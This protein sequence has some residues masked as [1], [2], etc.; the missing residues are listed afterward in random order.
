MQTLED[1]SAELKE[2]VRIDDLNLRDKQMMLPASKHKWIARTMDF[3]RQ[4]NMLIRKKKETKEHVLRALETNG[5][6]NGIPKA[7][8]NQKI[9]SSDKIQKINESIEDVELL[10]EYLEKVEQ[11][12]KSMSFDFSNLVK[13]NLSETT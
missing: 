10:I 4:R 2:D 9:E 6:P 8:L 5:I 13:I 1:F 11:V 3:K 7:S 12:F